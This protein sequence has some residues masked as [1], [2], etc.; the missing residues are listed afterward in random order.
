MDKTINQI[1]HIGIAH[2]DIFKNENNY[3]NIGFNLTK[4]EPLISIDSKNSNRAR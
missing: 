4:L 3:K 1:D 2:S